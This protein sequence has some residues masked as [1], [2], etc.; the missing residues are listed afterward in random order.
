M[1]K[2]TLEQAINRIATASK[3]EREKIVTMS[4]ELNTLKQ[5]GLGDYLG[6]FGTTDRDDT[7]SFPTTNL[8]DKARAIGEYLKGQEK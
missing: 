8:V 1:A 2:I 4:S 6:A 5:H 3:D 7:T